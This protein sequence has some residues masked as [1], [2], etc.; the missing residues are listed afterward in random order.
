MDEQI[1][2]YF[3]V[4]VFFPLFLTL[5]SILLLK[6]K[7]TA[8]KPGLRLPPGPWPLPIIGNIHNLM[9]SLPHQALQNLSLQ[10]GPIMNL[11]LG[12]IHAVI[13]TSPEAAR[14]IMK[15]HDITFATRPINT[16]TNILTGGGRGLLLAPY[17]E[18]WRQMRKICIVEL[19]NLKR[20]QSFSIIREQEIEDLI[21]SISSFSSIN[22]PINLRDQLDVLMN[23]ITVRTVI[24][25][26]CK[27]QDIFL[28][29]L[30]TVAELAAGFNLID[31]FPSSQAVS[32]LSKVPS[33]AKRAIKT[34]TEIMD[35]V[36][37]EHMARKASGEG[38]IESLL[39]VLLKIKEE[40]ALQFP[41]TM[42]TIK[43]VISDL[44][45]AGSETAS[46]TVE[47]AMAE[48]IRNPRVMKQ[49]QSEV[50]ELL[51][52]CTRVKDSDLV[53]LNYLHLVIKE[54]LRLHPPAPLLLPRQ[55]RETC[56]IL[57]YDIPKGAT[58]LV[59]AWAIG[60]DPNYWEDPELFMPERFINSNIDFKGTDFEFLPFGSGR[61]MCPGM[62]FGLANVELTLA[63]LLYH[64]DWK[65]PN[66]ITPTEVNM[67]EAMGLTVRRKAPLC[68]HAVQ[69]A[70]GR[71]GK[72][73]IDD[74]RH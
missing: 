1:S 49:A 2:S 37:E 41:L 16:T 36:I 43:P 66:D 7:A 32:M 54:T 12:E 31:L 70:E 45:G 46:T 25:S 17:G 11:R 34:I 33:E 15:T 74:D 27:D 72:E 20:V 52:G 39:D 57:G 14:E 64:F 69:Q 65:I 71:P 13:I 44:F 24:G 73:I 29:E 47:W 23:D 18:Y 21:R 38:D 61:R 26:K 48:L 42:D 30:E 3:C 51:R 68:L 62:S 40:D 50:R 5:L 8:T 28:K 59:N 10:Y 4:Y 9:A 53:R 35:G 60:R 22:Q 56:H 67:S 6:L 58:V 55:C 63:S 19:L